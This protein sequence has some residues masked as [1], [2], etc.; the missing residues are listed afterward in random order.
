[1]RAVIRICT[2]LG[3][4]DTRATRGERDL[5]LSLNFVLATLNASELLSP[6]YKFIFGDYL[7]IIIRDGIFLFIH[8][9]AQ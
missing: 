3:G 8:A 4:N 7:Y 5:D 9:R 6:V 2:A 1:M